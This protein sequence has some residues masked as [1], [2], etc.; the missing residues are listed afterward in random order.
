MIEVDASIDHPC[1]TGSGTGARA[2]M[3]PGD[4]P[5][6][7]L[8]RWRSRGLAELTEIEWPS[9]N[10]LHFLILL[11]IG[12]VRIACLELPRRASRRGKSFNAVR[13][14]VPE[15]RTRRARC[16]RPHIGV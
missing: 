3:D 10:G 14:N 16:F 6:H 1:R 11:A 4:A 2:A 15:A 12:N 8:R 9:L 7:T 5:G 13:I